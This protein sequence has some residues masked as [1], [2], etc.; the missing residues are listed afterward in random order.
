MVNLHGVS[1]RIHTYNAVRVGVRYGRRFFLPSDQRA[2]Y[3]RYSKTLLSVKRLFS[4]L[5][6]FKTTE[7]QFANKYWSLSFD[8][9]YF[10]IGIRTLYGK[11]FAIKV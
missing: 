6:E 7:I 11:L 9:I 3:E 8:N 1:T 5:I 2:F 10:I 4:L